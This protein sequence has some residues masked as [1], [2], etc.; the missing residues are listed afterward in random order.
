MTAERCLPYGRQSIDNADIAAVVQVLRGDWL[1]Q[2]PAVEVFEAALCEATGARFAVAMSHGTAALHA[3]CF[4]ANIGPG[5]S[6]IVPPIT[7]AASANCA[8]Y[9]GA[10]VIFA[11]VDPDVACLDV[12]AVKRAIKPNTKALIPVHFAGQPVA[13]AELAEVARDNGLVLIEDAAHALGG[14]YRGAPIGSC[15]FGDMAAFSFHPVKHITTGEGGAVTT[16]DPALAER[17]RLFR[18]HG[19]ERD[20]ARFSVPNPGPWYHEQVELG[21]N[22]RL[23]D[24]QAALGAS[25]MAKLGPWIARRQIIAARYDAAFAG[26]SH[27]KPL[28][29]TA[30]GEHAYHLYVVRID[31]VSANTT[32]TDVMAGLRAR[33][34]G[35]QVHYIPLYRHPYHAAGGPPAAFPNAEAY[36]AQALSLPMFATLTDAEVDHV[37]AAVR[38][39]VGG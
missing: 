29:R 24:L 7:F 14:S 18:N 31:F 5:D 1:T 38:E 28:A 35:T 17:L 22:F 33:G 37:V 2:G 23:T 27:V 26:F 9:Q 20:P 11:D 16:N 30:E 25:Q 4:A 3:A 34:V 6:V 8:R 15:Q 13:L 10:D 12:E 32:R 39:V 36:Y 19:M 21:Y